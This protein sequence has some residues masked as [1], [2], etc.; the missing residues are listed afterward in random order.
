[1]AF[2][3]EDSDCCSHCIT[4]S[5]HALYYLYALVRAW[6]CFNLPLLVDNESSLQAFRSCSQAKACCHLHKAI[7]SSAYFCLRIGLV[8]LLNYSITDEYQHVMCCRQ[9]T[10]LWQKDAVGLP[11][12]L[13]LTP[14]HHALFDRLDNGR[15]ATQ[16]GCGVTIQDVQDI[17]SIAHKTQ[18]NDS[19]QLFD[20]HELGNAVLGAT[21][22]QQLWQ[23]MYRSVFGKSANDAVKEENP[24][25]GLFGLQIKPFALPHQVHLSRQ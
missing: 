7:L 12:H 2:T 18:L 23:A 20:C 10:A 8:W 21:S 15:L 3:S 4:T 16:L 9:L 14:E 25:V 6:G 17:K 13:T 22:K 19:P 5:D 11:R 1:M 24:W